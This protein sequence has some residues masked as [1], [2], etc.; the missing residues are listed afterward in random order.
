MGAELTG[1]PAGPLN[2]AALWIAQHANPTADGGAMK[3][4]M[5]AVAAA[6]KS[7]AVETSKAVPDGAQVQSLLDE[8][9]NKIG[10]CQIAPG[11]DFQR[12][13]VSGRA[14]ISAK[15]SSAPT[16]QQSRHGLKAAS[17]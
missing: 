8:I 6:A 15:R 2:A 12:V 3:A 1:D 7:Y 10:L 11:E 16:R 17:T 14:A 4:K 9:F 5:E 13:G